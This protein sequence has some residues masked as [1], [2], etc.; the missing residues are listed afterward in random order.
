M[1]TIYLAFNK[2]ITT[3]YGRSIYHYQRFLRY[4]DSSTYTHVEII[5]GNVWYTSI[6][7]EGIRGRYKEH[8]YTE[9]NNND[10]WEFIPIEVSYKTAMFIAKWYTDR[11]DCGY[12]WL[13]IYLSQIFPLGIDDPHRWFCS[14]SVHRV[15]MLTAV[16]DDE[17]PSNIYGPARLYDLVTNVLPYINHN[18]NV[19]KQ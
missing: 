7:P 10:E 16:I 2:N 3:L 13:G 6:T 4:G 5:V 14:E 11:A 1:E 15:L 12:D 19:E 17:K 9:E 8:D 18:K